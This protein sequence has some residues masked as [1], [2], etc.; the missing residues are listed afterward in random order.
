MDSL[1]RI[2][3][4]DFRPKKVSHEYRY[5]LSKIGETCKKSQLTCIFASQPT[6]YKKNASDQ[7]KSKF[8]VTP[9]NEDY[10]LNFNSMMHIANLYNNFTI[11]YALENNFVPCNVSEKIPPTLDYLWDDI[12]FNVGG[13]EKA[14]EIIFECI[15]RSLNRNSINPE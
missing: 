5:F 7:I 12:H 9:H 6:A 1:N 8:W 14:G 3:K 10:T 11:S 15:I 4:R 2:D 13:A